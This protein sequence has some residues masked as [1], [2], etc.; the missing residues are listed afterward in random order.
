MPEIDQIKSDQMSLLQNKTRVSSDFI[1]LVFYQGEP[2]PKGEK[3]DRGTSGEPVSTAK[4][5]LS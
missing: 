5:F 1:C 2:G 4:R 3:G